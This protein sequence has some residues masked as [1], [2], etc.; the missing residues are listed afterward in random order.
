M[1]KKYL[2]FLATD[3]VNLRY[4]LRSSIF[5]MVL[6]RY[7]DIKNPQIPCPEYYTIVCVYMIDTVMYA[8]IL[9]ISWDIPVS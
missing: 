8:V 7:S 1:I 6:H 5:K 2:K 4:T 9:Q 3:N